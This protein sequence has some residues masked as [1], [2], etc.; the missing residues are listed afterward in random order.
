[1]RL[2]RA[3]ASLSGKVSTTSRRHFSLPC[4]SQAIWA[5]S[6]P[7]LMR[8]RHK[9]R[10]STSV[11]NQGF[12]LV[13]SRFLGEGCTREEARQIVGRSRITSVSFADEES[14]EVALG[15]EEPTQHGEPHGASCREARCHF[16]ANPRRGGKVA[17]L[18]LAG[19]GSPWGEGRRRRG[20]R[21]WRGRCRVSRADGRRSC[22]SRM[23]VFWR[24]SAGSLAD[25]HQ[26]RRQMPCRGGQS[27]RVNPRSACLRELP[28]R[29]LMK[30]A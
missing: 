28:G 13:Q 19:V 15:G 17:G 20:R 18:A 12:R 10:G 22:R 29:R 25:N 3:S 26:P 9:W 7:A 6:Y 27:C 5:F 2:H 16:S 4:G 24:N 30:S 1:M 14:F 21:T 23:R 11:S 8:P